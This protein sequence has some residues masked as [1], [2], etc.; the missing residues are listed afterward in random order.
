MIVRFP[1]LLAVDDDASGLA[2]VELQLAQRYVQEYRVVCLADATRRLS[3]SESSR[4]TVM[5]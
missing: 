1:V 3:S 5:R 2:D 4:T